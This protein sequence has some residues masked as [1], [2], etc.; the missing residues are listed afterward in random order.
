VRNG[1]GTSVANNSHYSYGSLQK[2]H[3]IGTTGAEVF[4][5]AGISVF[6]LI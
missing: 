5:K 2:N 4:V 6:N 3:A 1:F